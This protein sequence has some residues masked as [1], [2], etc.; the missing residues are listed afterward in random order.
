MKVEV[1]GDFEAIMLSE[2]AIG[3]R[4]VKRTM[5]I[6]GKGLQQDWRSQIIGAGLG[7]KLPRTIRAYTYP[8]REDSL[9]AAALVYSNAPKIIGAFDRGVL[10]RSNDGFWLAIPTPEAGTRGLGRERITPGGWERR[11]GIRLRFVY[12]RNNLSLLVAD[13]ARIN[14]RGRAALNRRKARKDGMRTG[15]V[16]VPIFILVPQAQLRKRLD[17]NRDAEKW[18]GRIPQLIIQN[19]PES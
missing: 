16:T 11:T 4:A 14:T 12:R 3:E 5:S 8:V 9:N 19:W 1:S 10:I 13:S 15:D 17:L 6:A 7:S 2:V 18:F